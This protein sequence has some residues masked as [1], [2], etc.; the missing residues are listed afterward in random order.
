MYCEAPLYGTWFIVM[1][2]R[3]LKISAIRWCGEPTP[4]LA[5][6]SLPGLAFAWAISSGIVFTGTDG[7]ATNTKGSTPRKASGTKD[8]I[9]S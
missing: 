8:L 9:G 4:A 6:V 3:L 2:L 7:C 1:P 5:Q